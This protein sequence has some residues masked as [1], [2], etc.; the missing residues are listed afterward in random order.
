MK[1]LCLFALVAFLTTGCDMG[2]IGPGTADF[3]TELCGGYSVYRTSAHQIMIAPTSGWNDSTPI[4]PEKVCELGHDHR[5]IVAKQNHLKR[6]SPDNPQDTY[7]E[8]NPGV[9]SYW[10]LDTVGP[11]VYGP[12]TMEKFLQ[13][14][15]ELG[16]PDSITLKDVYEYRK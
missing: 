10:I 6:R 2:F 15:Q 1:K 14:R 4:I 11:A 13:K 5:F 9:F 3:I 12:L 16:V 7:M 8:P